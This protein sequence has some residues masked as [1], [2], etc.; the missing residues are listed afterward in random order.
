MR[1][2]PYTIFPTI[3]GDAISLRQIRPTDVND[4]IEISFYDAVQA[5]TLQQAMEMQTKINTDYSNGNSIHWGIV[6]NTTDKIIG[7]CGYYRGFN[8]GS[9][10]LGCVLLAQHRGQGFMAAAMALVID[11]GLNTI[12]LKSISAITTHQNHKAIKLLERLN[13]LKMADL[14]DDYIEYKLN[15][16]I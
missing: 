9:G 1:L 3:I 5:T 7:T 2:P 16:N 15:Q 6:E 14:E 12:R 8:K 13:F 11:F 10:E 4:I